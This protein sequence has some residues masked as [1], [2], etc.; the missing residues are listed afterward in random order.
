[1][2]RRVIVEKIVNLKDPG[3]GELSGIKLFSNLYVSINKEGDLGIFLDNVDGNPEAPNLEN[4]DFFPRMNYSMKLENGKKSVLSNCVRVEINGDT[5]PRTIASIIELMIDSNADPYSFDDLMGA[6]NKYR[7]LLKG[8]RNKLSDEE[9]K[10]LWGELWFLKEM[11]YRCSARDQIEHCLNA[12]KS[13]KNAKRDFRFPV[14]KIIFE[15]K[16]TEKKTRSHEIS[17]KNQ[18][19]IQNEEKAAYIVSVGVIREDSGVSHTIDSLTKIITNKIDDKELEKKLYNLL[20][21][22]GWEPENKQDISLLPSIENPMALFLFE[23]VPTILPLPNG[24]SDA[25]WEVE[26]NPE[27]EILGRKQNEIFKMALSTKDV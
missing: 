20:K 21:E 22:R 19:M 10:G 27:K 26:L 7:K 5:D 15:I 17:S 3:F 6:I 16:T 4:I 24:V 8:S 11:I 9:L 1:M 18:L 25:K 12:W 2:D 23:D 13:S 14:S